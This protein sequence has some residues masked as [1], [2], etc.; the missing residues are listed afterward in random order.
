MTAQ[1][2]ILISGI[3][4]LAYLLDLSAKFT[5]IPTV[6]WLLSM[7]WGLQQFTH[8]AQIKVPSLNG[9]LPVFGT[10]GLILIV[11]EGALDLKLSKR[12]IPLI[13]SA[14]LMA[15][16]PFVAFTWLFAWALVEVEQTTWRIAILNALPFAIISS[17][18]AIPS[19]KNFK[20][21]IRAFI[22]YE[23]SISDIIGVLVFNFVLINNVYDFPSVLGFFGDILIVF[24]LSII[25]SIVLSFLLSRMSHHVKY[26][27][28]LLLILLLYGFS[29][30]W[31]LPGLIFILIF[32]LALSNLH[33]FREW[34]IARFF[35]PEK[36]PQE[37]KQFS[38]I[39][40]EATFLIRSLF[41][42]L[43][44]FMIQTEDLLNLNT[45]PWS[46]GLVSLLFSLR[47]L[48]LWLTKQSLSPYL[49]VAPRGLITIL[50]YLSIPVSLQLKIVNQSLIIQVILWSILVMMLGLIFHKEPVQ[51][52]PPHDTH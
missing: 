19:V 10:I 37:I 44:G 22:T 25:L 39:V 28:I 38:D 27:P 7:G 9:I 41:F 2:L 17:A 49:F 46:V 23:S 18:I 13:S 11:L 52:T 24:I 3:L 26:G 35:Q 45:L 5:R 47:F 31:H 16:L 14:F 33:L 8:F 15:L 43:F 12:A 51:N 30:L 20:V 42:V 48:F 40:A 6:I 1:L 34:R 32:G 29:K 21:R 36:I 50:L 4:L